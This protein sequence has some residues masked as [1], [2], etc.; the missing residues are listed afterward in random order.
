MKKLFNSKPLLGIIFFVAA[1]P[2]TA[3][4][5]N[6]GAAVGVIGAL[7]FVVSLCRGIFAKLKGKKADKPSAL[8]SSSVFSEPVPSERKPESVERIHVR[9]I[10][11]YKKNIMAVATE[12]SD[13][14]MSKKE[15][16]EEYPDER[17]WQ[18]SFFPKCDLVPEPTN[19]YD[20]NAIM[21]QAD[22]LCIGYVPKGSTSH[23]RNLMKSGRIKWIDLKI[24]GGKYK[25]VYENEDGKY[26]LDRGEK[27]YSAIVELHLI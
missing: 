14:D 18:Y 2:L 17:V 13:Y 10:S 20:P 7:L 4:N 26:E 9:G 22:G 27:E 15:L 8:N 1:F 11:N 19:E 24:G 25:Y 16:E 6:I 3:L 21:V 5:A 12:N 23:V